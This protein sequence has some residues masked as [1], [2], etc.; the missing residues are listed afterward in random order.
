MMCPLFQVDLTL[1]LI[2]GRPN[3]SVYIVHLEAI[4][5]TVFITCTFQVCT[6]LHF[7]PQASH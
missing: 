3:N 5:V 4:F 7:I 2:L 6:G 1:H